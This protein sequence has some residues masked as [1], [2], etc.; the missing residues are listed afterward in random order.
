M[1]TLLVVTAASGPRAVGSFA[2]NPGD[3][4]IRG[5]CAG[6]NLNLHLEPLAVLPIPCDRLNNLP[7]QNQI[8]LRRARQ[9]T[10][11]VVAPEA[12]VWGL[13]V[14]QDWRQHPER[15]AA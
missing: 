4:W 15:Q 6:G 2:V 12:M 7:F 5:R 3:L 11:S 1:T 8:T 10:L 13:R 9:V 14:E